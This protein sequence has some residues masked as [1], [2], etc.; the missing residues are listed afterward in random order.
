MTVTASTRASASWAATASISAGSAGHST[1]PRWS[2]RAEISS[3]RSRGT[4]GVSLASRKLN[5]LG[6]C[7][8]PISSTPRFPLETTSPIRAPRRRMMAFNASVVPCT[9]SSMS[10]AATP[11]RAIKAGIPRSTDKEGSPGT[12]GS[13]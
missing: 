3:T 11:A 6:S 5:A 12:L 10:A 8:R 2:S 1:W 7:D 13:L 4:S 9:T